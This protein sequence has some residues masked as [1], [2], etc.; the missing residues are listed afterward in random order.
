MYSGLKIIT[1]G[2]LGLFLVACGGPSSPSPMDIDEDE[3]AR[4]VKAKE[5]TWTL[6]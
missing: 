4:A 2:V 1:F 3:L 6:L 5:R